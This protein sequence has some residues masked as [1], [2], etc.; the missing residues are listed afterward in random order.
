MSRLNDLF[1]LT[2]MMFSLSVAFFYESVSP[3][4]ENW[5]ILNALNT[6]EAPE[7]NINN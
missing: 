6:N 5:I 3:A 1:R 4:K 7:K 2:L